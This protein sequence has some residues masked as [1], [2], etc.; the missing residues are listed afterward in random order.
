MKNFKKQ[1]FSWFVIIKV[2][3]HL[4]FVMNPKIMYYNHLDKRGKHEKR[5]AFAF[6]AVKKWAKFV[7]RTAK[8]NITVEGLEKIPADSPI[9]FTPNHQSY[10]DIPVLLYALS[11]FNFG[12]MMKISLAGVPF[13]S[14]ISKMLKSVPVNQEN[15]REA[16]KAIHKTI[17]T[18]EGGHSMLIFPEGKRVFS[19]TPEEF[20]NGADFVYLHFEAPDEC[21][22]RNEPENKV[23]SIEI[24]D[25]IVLSTLLKG[26]E[27]YDDYKIM[28]LPDHPTP[29]VTKTHARDPVPYMIYHKSN[30]KKGVDTINEETA[31]ATGNFIENG[32]GLMSHFINC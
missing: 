4:L 14:S 21:G 8:L 29:I 23:R 24:I 20:K 11:D 32:A 6:K 9:L 12:F 18:I 22:H 10:A 2:I 3:G 25:E 31:K 27:E 1:A 30:P 19:N 28:I 5:D 7:V 16:V 26:L 13:I 15:P 17:E